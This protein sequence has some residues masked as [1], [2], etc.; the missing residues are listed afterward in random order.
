MIRVLFRLYNIVESLNSLPL[1][2]SPECLLLWENQEIWVRKRATSCGHTVHTA[3]PHRLWPDL[4]R[5]L[6]YLPDPSSH[7]SG[8]PLIWTRDASSQPP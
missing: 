6:L 2:K 7:W 3:S 4:L 8:R 5:S 1:L